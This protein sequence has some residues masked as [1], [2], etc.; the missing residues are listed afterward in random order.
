MLERLKNV[1]HG[2]Q[3]RT[4]QTK[5]DSIS[6]MDMR[7]LDGPVRPGHDSSGIVCAICR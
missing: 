5:K 4:I 2:L 6:R 7:V 3:Q 1:C